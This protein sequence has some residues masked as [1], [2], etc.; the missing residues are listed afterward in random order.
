MFGSVA[1]GLW[2][3]LRKEG[4]QDGDACLFLTDMFYFLCLICTQTHRKVRVCGFWGAAAAA[5]AVTRRPLGFLCHV[6]LLCPHHTCTDARMRLVT[7]SGNRIFGKAGFGW[8]H[9][10]LKMSDLFDSQ[11]WA[12]I[13]CIN[14][15][16]LGLNYFHLQRK[17]FWLVTRWFRLSR[18]SALTYHG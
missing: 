2:L 8:N 3:A 9:V 13:W 6:C 1:A 7:K 15:L 12:V 18:L 11:Q 4:K 5:E 16:A 17:P 10:F 14:V